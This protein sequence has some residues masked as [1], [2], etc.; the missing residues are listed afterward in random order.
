VAAGHGAFTT[1]KNFGKS[2]PFRHLLAT[3]KRFG[4]KR[5]GGVGYSVIEERFPRGELGQ[6][7]NLCA[8]FFKQV[9]CFQQSTL[10]KP[11]ENARKRR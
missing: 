1:L 10:E 2:F 4:S 8:A 5:F 3:L 7:R 11:R 9:I 6:P